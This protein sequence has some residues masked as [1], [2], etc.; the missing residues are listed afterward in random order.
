MGYMSSF[1]NAGAQLSASS[2]AL[3]HAGV[4]AYLKRGPMICLA[5]NVV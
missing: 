1:I 5:R 4:S 2:V 3:T